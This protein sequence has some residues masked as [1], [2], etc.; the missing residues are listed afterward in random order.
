MINA[1]EELDPV[2]FARLLK[3]A[4]RSYDA[5]EPT[6]LPWNNLENEVRMQ[7]IQGAFETLKGM[8]MMDPYESVALLSSIRPLLL[9]G[10]NA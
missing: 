1:A 4:K 10:D 6:G 8:S 3:L 9:V 2:N 7:N 5:L